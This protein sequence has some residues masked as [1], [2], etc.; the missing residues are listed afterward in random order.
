[1]QFEP[2]RIPQWLLP[3][4]LVILVLILM[5]MIFGGYKFHA[6]GGVFGFYKSNGLETI[7]VDGQCFTPVT[8]K[9]CQ[10]SFNE[11][12]SQDHWIKF[13]NESSCRESGYVQEKVETILASCKKSNDE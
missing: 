2:V 1:M 8:I 13:E 9:L 11:G 4:L 3:S 5:L 10:A 12:R 6:Q 7:I